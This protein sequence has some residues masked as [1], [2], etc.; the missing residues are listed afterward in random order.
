MILDNIIPTKYKILFSVISAGIWIYLRTP[1]HYDMI[2]RKE[3]LPVIFVMGWAYINY[4]EPLALPIGLS[5]LVA[6]TAINEYDYF[7]VNH[8]FETP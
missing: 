2:P 8:S 1:Q 5:I 7:S 6:Y 3:I 4:Y